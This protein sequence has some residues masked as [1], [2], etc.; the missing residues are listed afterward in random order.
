[1]DPFVAQAVSYTQ[2]EVTWNE[3]SG[4]WTGFRVVRNRNG[5]AVNENDGTVV[6]SAAQPATGGGFT[7]FVSSPGW[8]YY[9]AYV[10]NADN[11]AWEQAAVAWAL[12]P[13]DHGT[14][15]SMWSAIPD[16]YQKVRD[17]TAG[18][19]PANYAANPAIYLGAFGAVDN[20]QF[21]SFVGVF[22]YGMD[23]LRTQSKTILWG[24]D[25]SRMHSER[26]ALLADQFGY[27]IERSVPPEAVRNLVRNLAL[28]YRIRG[29]K[30]GI[31]ELAALA[32]G[33]QVDVNMG[34]NL[35]LSEDQANFVNPQ[36]PDWDK[37]SKYYLVNPI[38]SLPDRVKFN[39]NYFV[40]VA[41]SFN[42]S[43]PNSGNNASWNQSVTV[44]ENI[45]KINQR[46][47]NVSTWEAVAYGF[48]GPLTTAT[49]TH[50]GRGV[51][52]PT[53]GAVTNT[54]ALGVKNTTAS[55]RDITLQS[56]PWDAT[57]LSTFDR[58]VTLQSVVPVPYVA[59]TY[60]SG[61]KYAQGEAVIYNGISYEALRPTT[62]LPTGADWKAL[63][64]DKR[65]RLSLSMYAHGPFTGS[66]GTGGLTTTPFVLAFDVNGD[67]VFS[68]LL[69]S[70]TVTNVNYDSF[71][72]AAALNAGKALDLGGKT[73]GTVAGTWSQGWDDGN[74]YYYP[75]NASQALAGVSTTLADGTVG[76]TFDSVGARPMGILFRYSNSTNYW[77]VSATKL[78]KVVAGAATDVA[79]HSTPF[80]AGDRMNV[81]L[82]GSSITVK[83]NGASVA[84]AT[85]AFNS[86]AT[87]HGIVVEP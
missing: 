74:G 25:P 37:N 83:R 51:T 31:E 34:P 85:D 23:I 20:L 70:G 30:R 22:A 87:I 49:A 59:S 71:N 45:E 35:M 1:M 7:D 44:E 24:R 26:L 2:I 78:T 19:S 15:D 9:T 16:H 43:P 53:D 65:A 82:N 79:T 12:L 68:T 64:Y 77:R 8:Y 54:N 50:I 80:A 75:A 32:T 10:Y 41:D 39:G 3:P 61:T 67:L 29:T 13:E 48:E 57:N 14:L 52:D 4:N 18:Y 36:V 46:T 40:A 66:A 84:T 58:E 73:F 5:A 76:V 60:V 62:G 38:S 11:S 28:L 63:G 56:V 27:E 69:D 86:T 33:W 81:V 47:L 55:T 72:K 42:V 21:K 6:Y 17:D